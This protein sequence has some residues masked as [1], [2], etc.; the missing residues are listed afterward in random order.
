VIEVVNNDFKRYYLFYVAPLFFFI[1]IILLTGF[2]LIQAAIFS[3]FYLWNLTLLTKNIREQFMQKKMRL[4]FLRQVINLDLIITKILRIAYISKVFQLVLFAVI[5]HYS[6]GVSAIPF[7]FAGA[8]SLELI[9][10]VQSKIN[11]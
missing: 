10:L 1:L 4:S 5:I 6:F 3:F 2:S 11:R 9:F 7:V 8:V